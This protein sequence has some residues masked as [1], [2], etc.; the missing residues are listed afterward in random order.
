M[1][2]KDKELLDK[3]LATFKVEAQEHI[4]GI[5]SGLVELEKASAG[6]GFLFAVG[7]QIFAE[8]AEATE[9]A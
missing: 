3:L 9:A 1:G 4:Q 2:L 7:E 8:G 5:D 6:E